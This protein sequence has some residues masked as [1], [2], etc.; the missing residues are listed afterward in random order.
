MLSICS[1]KHFHGPTDPHTETLNS[2]L[3]IINIWNKNINNIV[4]VV[5]GS[6]NT[7]NQFIYFKLYLVN[8]KEIMKEKFYRISYKLTYNDNILQIWKFKT[9]CKLLRYIK[10]T[11]YKLFHNNLKTWN[12][13]SL[14]CM[15]VFH[16]AKKRA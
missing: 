1:R 10:T 8:L 7:N 4:V 9:F 14:F 12:E 11:N 5:V 6:W 13:Y 15:T 3:G 2:A 16:C